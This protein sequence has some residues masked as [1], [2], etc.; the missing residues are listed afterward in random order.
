MNSKPSLIQFVRNKEYTIDT[1]P[2]IVIASPAFL[3]KPVN[4]LQ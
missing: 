1:D 2:T 3:D 4:I